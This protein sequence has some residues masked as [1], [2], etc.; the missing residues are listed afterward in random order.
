MGFL[1][2]DQNILPPSDDRIFK[3]ILTA[4]E[5]KPALIDLISAT[6]GRPVVDAIVR[7]NELPP[8][9]IDE[10]G[11]RFDVNCRT[12]DDSQ[13]DAEMEAH[14]QEEAGNHHQNLKG[15]CIYYACD[16]HSSQPSKGLYRY[17]RLARTYQVTFC[18]YTVFPHKTHFFHSFSFRHDADSEQLSD[19][20][21]IMFIE[22]SKLKPLLAKPV[23]SMSGLEK[24][25]LFLRYASDPRR[26]EIVNNIIASKE[27][28][29][30]AGNLLMNVSQDER[31]RAIFRSRRMYQTDLQ[32]NLATAEDRGRNE[33]IQ[34]GRSEG[35]Q[36][37]RS[38]GI[39]IGRSEGERNRNLAIAQKLLSMGEP[40]ERIM[41]ITDLS[42]QEI[43]NLR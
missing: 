8:T 37:G 20:L 4:P 32:S 28:F 33:G 1:P 36:L 11:E 21:H 24:W 9:D 13:V 16:L 10:K 15:K 18:N 17:D 12:D 35:I 38:E 34:I 25:A 41:Q 26:R 19:A 14:L 6:I 5:A 29:Q 2:N 39:Q 40:I 27:V 31:E 30:V 3:L 7:N 23:D 22:L 43:I 42:Y